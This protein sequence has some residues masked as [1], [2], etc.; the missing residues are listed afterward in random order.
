MGL[1]S[2]KEFTSLE[3]LFLDQIQD[4]YDA[5]NRLTN[6]LPQMAD[7]ALSVE[8]KST[9][10]TH[11]RDVDEH[12]KRLEVVFLEMRL[13]PRRQACEAMKRMIRMGDEMVKA[14][15]DPMVRDAALIATAQ[16]F[17]HYKIAGYGTARS[18][19]R[20]LGKKHLAAVLEANL[21]DENAADNI[22]TE[23]AEKTTNQA[24]ARS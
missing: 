8:L 19:A 13:E 23:I 7:A 5:E 14:K 4:L 22:L 18:F 24:A 16:R 6:M 10:R 1:I 11:V 12:L 9:F 20:R 15:G 21:E 3:D 2:R 17:D